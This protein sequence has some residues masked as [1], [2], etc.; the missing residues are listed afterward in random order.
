MNALGQHP[1]QS[2]L[3]IAALHLPPF[4]GSHHPEQKPLTDIVDYA[5]RNT[6]SAVKAGI[7]ALYLQ[8]LG[9]HPW[10]KRAQP[11]TVAMMSVV[12]ARVR[13]EFPDLMLGICL[14]SHGAIEPIA[15]AQ[16][17]QAQFVRLK[18][19][20]GA[21]VKAE[22]ILEGCAHEAI[23]YRA[24]TDAADIAIMVDVYDRTGRPLAEMPLTE[25]ARFA[26]VFGRA[27]GLILTGGS[28]DES[29][30]MLAEVKNAELGV[31]LFIGGS[32]NPDNITQAL[33]YCD[34]AIVSTAFKPV[35]SWKKSSLALDW[36]SGRIQTFMQKVQ[37]VKN[38]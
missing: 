17:I 19:Y 31:P 18:V 34:G 1:F 36:D 26:A 3:I 37:S 38:E 15:I 27:D 35:G 9:D 16:A 30:Q 10:S 25:E 24:E 28:F 32:A 33:A 13:Q 7:P 20:V 23:S 5:L 6:E 14:M 8:D 2:P 12:G 4:P 21:M 11:R 29:L 22:G